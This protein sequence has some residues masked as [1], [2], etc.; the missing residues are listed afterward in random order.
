MH[1][2]GQVYATAWNGRSTRCGAIGCERN[3]TIKRLGLERNAPLALFS[4][5][6]PFPTVMAAPVAAIHIPWSCSECMDGRDKPGHDEWWSRRDLHRLRT[7]QSFRVQ[8]IKFETILLN[9]WL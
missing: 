4:V 5:I 2:I 1:S 3:S 9:S 6:E 8:I 7:E